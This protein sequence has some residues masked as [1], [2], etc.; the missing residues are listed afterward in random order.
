MTI[1]TL[2]MF[3]ASTSVRIRVQRYSRNEEEK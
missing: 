3:F 1:Q 2:K